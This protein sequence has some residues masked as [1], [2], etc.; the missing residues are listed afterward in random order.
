MQA[1]GGCFNWAAI[2]REAPLGAN[3]VRRR[4]LDYSGHPAIGQTSNLNSPTEF[5]SSYL[6]PRLKFC[7]SIEQ[8]P[9][10]L[11][12]SN[13]FGNNLCCYFGTFPRVYRNSRVQLAY[14]PLCAAIGSRG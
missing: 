13:T 12:G 2:D 9:Y 6:I 8:L 14:D 10:R 5:S 1:N 3:I 7:T 4:N 11:S